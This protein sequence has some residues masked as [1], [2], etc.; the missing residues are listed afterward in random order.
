MASESLKARQTKYAA[1]AT[2][3]VLV[4][5]AAIVIANVLADRYNKSYD[6]TANKRYSLSEQTAK[7]V[8][9]LTQPATITYFNQSTRFHEGKDLLDEYANLSPKVHVEYVDADKDPQA[10]REAGVSK[11]G[12]A[13]VQIGLKK[14]EAKNMTEEGVTGA[15][16]RDLK[17]TTRSVCFVAGSGEH[18]LDDSERE[19][20][21]HF[22]DGLAKEDYQTKSIDLLQ[23]AEVPEDCTALVIAG[24]TRNY[25]QFEVDALKKY[26]E[27]GGRALFLLDPPLK[28]GH[29]EIADNDALTNLLS[30][31]GIT[32]DKDLILDLN[33]LGQIAGVGPQVALVTTYDSQPIVNDMKGVA[34]GFPLSR[35]LEIKNADKTSV[36][37]MFDS[38][39][40]SLATSDLSSPSVNMKDP[41][42]KQG[43]FTI[44]AAGT[45][46][47][48]KENSQ[49]RFVVVGSSSWIANRFFDWNG[50]GDLAL[51][52]INWLASDEDLISI[53]PKQ[54]EDR[55]I[56]MTHAQMSWVRVTSQFLLPLIV[57][58][59]GVGVWWKRR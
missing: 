30:S 19:G 31:W 25:E 4:V 26:V 16:I 37:K 59:T 53:R 56:T 29:S 48:G 12:T 40:S 17:S 2:S 36:Q 18:Q 39:D 6:S 7:I 57:V 52:T 5:I 41:K 24:P 43:P 49:G 38:S 9:G 1:Y 8:K 20:L 54:E 44:G 51:N 23:K 42:N 46:T 58:F 34:T 10:T 21:S 35:S 14:E 3:Y 28:L 27:A 32:A 15:F 33:P 11:Y 55:R 45:Y 47:T 50:N 13:I 22:K